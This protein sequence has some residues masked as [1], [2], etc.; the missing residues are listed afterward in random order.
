MFHFKKEKFNMTLDG[1]YTYSIYLN[2]YKLLGFDNKL[3][4]TEKIWFLQ[5]YKGQGFVS[6]WPLKPAWGLFF[7]FFW[8]QGLRQILIIYLMGAFW[9]KRWNRLQL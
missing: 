5:V 7:F 4:H 6:L 8:P 2:Q 1:F 9:I 3:S